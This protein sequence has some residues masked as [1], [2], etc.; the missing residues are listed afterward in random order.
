MCHISWRTE[1]R[2]CRDIVGFSTRLNVSTRIFCV[3]PYCARGEESRPTVDRVVKAVPCGKMPAIT[4]CSASTGG[5]AYRNMNYTKT[6]APLGSVFVPSQPPI[7]H[8]PA[9]VWMFVFF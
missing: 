4:D 5:A 2:R 6:A 8:L 7:Y 3:D 9:Y 1:W